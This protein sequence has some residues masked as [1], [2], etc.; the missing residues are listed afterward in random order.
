MKYLAQYTF[1]EHKDNSVVIY[2]KKE[3]LRFECPDDNTAHKTARDHRLKMAQDRP[4]TNVSLDS[5]LQ[6]R[7]VN[8][9]N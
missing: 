6:V 1:I 4:G 2:P 8:I 9:D 5:L 3:E 7:D